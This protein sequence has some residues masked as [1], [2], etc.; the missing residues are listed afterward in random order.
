[1]KQLGNIT[2]KYIRT[3]FYSMAKA[4]Y[5]SDWSFQIWINNKTL[6]LPL[7]NT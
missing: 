7:W 3:V 4:Q 1:M 6:T 2:L 5:F